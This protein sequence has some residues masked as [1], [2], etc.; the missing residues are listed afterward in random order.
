MKHD[1]MKLTTPEEEELLAKKTELESL[2]EV[3]AEKEL[4]L[5]DIRLAVARFQHRYFAEIGKK[6]VQ[7]DELRALIAGTAGKARSTRLQLK[8]RS[9]DKARGSR[10]D[11]Q[12]IQGNEHRIR[13]CSRRC[14]VFYGDQESIPKDRIRY[15]SGQ[16]HRR[17][18]KATSY[19]ANGRA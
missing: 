17:E 1:L 14:R 2:S 18:N 7:L 11:Y 12:R 15:S 19:T 13:T 3:L 16:S 5:E 9:K 10:Q 6:Y 4:D 8:E